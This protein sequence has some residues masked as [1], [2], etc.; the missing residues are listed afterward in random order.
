MKG[1]AITHHKFLFLVSIMILSGVVSIIITP[2]AQQELQL[3]VAC[4]K[5]I[6]LASKLT[7]CGGESDFIVFL[8]KKLS[9]QKK[10]GAQ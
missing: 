2:Q 10:N 1:V 4:D 7:S 9:F 5:K 8:T 3:D 6:I